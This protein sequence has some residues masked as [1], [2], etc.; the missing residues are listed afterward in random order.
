MKGL[1]VKLVLPGSLVSDAPDL[2]LKTLK[3]GQIGRLAAIFRV[4]EI[5]LYADYGYSEQRRE[6]LLLKK[7]LEYME[8]PQYL[9]KRL[10]PQ[11]PFLKYVGVLPPLASPHHPLESRKK[12]LHDGEFREGVVIESD[13]KGVLLDIGV[14]QPQRL[15]GVSLPVNTRITVRVIMRDGKFHLERVSRD[16]I[17]DY[18]GY[19]VTISNDSLSSTLRKLRPALI[20]LT[21][22]YG[23]VFRDVSEKL[24]EKWKKL[25]RLFLVFGGPYHGLGEILGKE[26]TSMYEVGDFVVNFVPNQGT[27]T[28]RTEE[29][30]AAALSV[31]NMYREDI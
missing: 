5:I 3:V 10:F 23:D 26:R 28:V 9:K 21:S 31:L 22:R 24:L 17:S 2:R 27:R 14:E 29:A 18:W 25:G 1:D 7:V 19:F 8:A 6:L 12:D 20:V 11:S 16:E 30:V 4:S 13:S 15:W